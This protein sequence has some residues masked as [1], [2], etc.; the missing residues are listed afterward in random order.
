MAKAIESVQGNVADRTKLIDALA[1]TS[2][3]DTVRGP[4]SFNKMNDIV[5][6]VNITRVVKSGTGLEA[7]DTQDLRQGRRTCAPLALI[8]TGHRDR[9][10]DMP[11]MATIGIQTFNALTWAMV[12]F[13][14]SAGL[15]I[16]YGQ[17]RIVIR[18]RIVLSNRRLYC[19][20]VRAVHGNYFLAL[21]VGANVIAAFGVIVNGWLSGRC[22]SHRFIKC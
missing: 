22:M 8:G 19:D 5:F 10:G 1:K 15:T 21:I 12:L 17:M 11:A 4:F 3:P 13:P 7:R 6:T 2:M 9:I 20:L 14:L 16:V 18:T